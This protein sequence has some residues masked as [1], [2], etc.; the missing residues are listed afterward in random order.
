MGLLPFETLSEMSETAEQEISATVERI[1]QKGLR[2]LQ[3]SLGTQIALMNN[4]W[5][6]H[7]LRE[8]VKLQMLD[9]LNEGLHMDVLMYSYPKG[10]EVS[11]VSFPNRVHVYCLNGSVIINN[12]LLTSVDA[13]A[14]IPAHTLHSVRAIEDSYLVAVFR[15]ALE[16]VKPK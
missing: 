16:R 12:E 9:L 5:S 13:P 11:D 3:M 6:A 2:I 1:K 7:P 8:G 4:E 14:I 15:P 10:E